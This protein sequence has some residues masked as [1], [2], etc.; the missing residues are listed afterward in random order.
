[1]G[2]VGAKIYVVGGCTTDCGTTDAFAYDPSTDT[3]A[4]VAPYPKPVAWESCGGV[5]ATLYCTGGTYQATSYTSTYAYDPA[6]N[7]WSQVA[8]LPIDLWGSGYAAVGDRLVVSGGLTQYSHVL[9]NQSFGYDPKTDT[10]TTLPNSTYPTYR[11]GSACGFYK[12]GGTA[13]YFSPLPNT[14]MLPGLDQCGGA[15]DVPWVAESPNHFT[16]AP[17]KSVTVSV[18]F[19]AAA[20]GITQPGTLTATL[21]VDEDTPY[22]PGDVAVT[23]NVTPPKKWGKIAGL[24]TGVNCDGSAVPVAGAVVQVDTWAGNVSLVTDSSGHYGYWLDTRSDPLTLIA[25]ADSWRP[26]TR[27]VRISAGLTTTSD[28]A[29]QTT[30]TCH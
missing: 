7:H 29:L 18:T 14:E 12:I 16:V 24:V 9:T 27:T 5:G 4:T 15:A 3:W 30:R 10:W 28:F 6:T 19:D 25:A 11:G 20:A 21:A 8:N 26:Q 1:V 2:V 22:D 13:G 17:G 23:M